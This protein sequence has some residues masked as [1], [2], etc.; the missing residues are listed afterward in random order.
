MR[1]GCTCAFPSTCGIW[2]V[3]TVFA[4]EGAKNVRWVW[5][6]NTMP[7]TRRA[8]YEEIYRSVYPGNDVVDWSGLDIYNGGA[9]LDSW[10]GWRTFREALIE[11]YDALHA[12]ADKPV[13]LPEVGSAEVGGAKAEWIRSVFAELQSGRFAAVRALVWFDV[14]K[15]ERWA[16]HSSQPALAAWLGAVR[17]AGA[18][19]EQFAL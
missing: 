17:A 16:V 10:G 12:V 4:E 15:E 1:S 13:I 14:D 5:N 9:T 11:P 7:G 18:P 3:H 19:S 2:H 6:P 8:A